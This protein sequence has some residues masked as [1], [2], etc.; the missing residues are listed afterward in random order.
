MQPFIQRIYNAGSTTRFKEDKSAV[1]LADIIVQELLHLLLVP[2]T[3]AFIGEESAEEYVIDDPVLAQE[4]ADARRAIQAL[5]LPATLRALNLTAVIDPIDGTAEFS[6]GKGHESTICIGFAQGTPVAGL[7]FRPIEGTYAAGCYS[8]GYFNTNLVRAEFNRTT[9]L[10][11]NGR[12][13]TFIEGL[14]LTRIPAGGCG[15]KILLLLEGRGIYILDRGV[16]R[17]DTCAAQ[18]ILEAEGGALCT[19]TGFLAGRMESYTYTLTD[20]NLDPNPLAIAGPMNSS[21]THMKPYSNLC[22]LVAVPRECMDS[23]YM[24]TLRSRCLSSSL[25]AYS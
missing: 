2:V 12:I 7:V 15:N 6:S 24:E 21:G 23:E 22:G 11:S 18:A 14:G 19:L 9:V 17:W 4:V 3:V 8:E 16:S 20:V 25:P 5:E 1:T 13:S 10:T